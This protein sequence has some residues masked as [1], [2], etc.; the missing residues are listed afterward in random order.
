MHVVDNTNAYSTV[1]HQHTRSYCRTIY[2]GLCM[3][4][5][6]RLECWHSRFPASIHAIPRYDCESESGETRIP[7]GIPIRRRHTVARCFCNV[8]RQCVRP[9]SSSASNCREFGVTR[10]ARGRPDIAWGNPNRPR[11]VNCPSCQRRRRSADLAR[12]GPES[13]LSTASSTIVSRVARPS[14]TEPRQS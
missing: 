3:W 14:A 8:A 5:V 1:L 10:D 7:E 13:E 11:A 9:A 2:P 4:Y 6:F 12:G